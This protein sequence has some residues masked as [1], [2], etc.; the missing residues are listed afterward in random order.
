LI[1]DKVEFETK[2]VLDCD[3]I[4]K[5]LFTRFRAL[6]DYHR[7]SDATNTTI[8]VDTELAK[9]FE[10]RDKLIKLNVVRDTPEYLHTALL[11]GKRILIEGANGVLLDI[12]FGRCF[13][14]CFCA[15]SIL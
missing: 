5:Y 13:I 9:C 14:Y 4:F 15:F 3:F 10:N 8:N 7:H 11:A 1:S 6:V 2:S 12:D